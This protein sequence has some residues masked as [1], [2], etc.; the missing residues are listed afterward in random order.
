VSAPTSFATRILPRL[1]GLGVVGLLFAVVL[2]WVVADT[3]PK[4]GN[5]FAPGSL[6]DHWINGIAKFAL[7]AGL[8]TVAVGLAGVAFAPGRR[9]FCLFMTLVAAG[10]AFFC[11]LA[12]LGNAICQY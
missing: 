8:A 3:A 7:F 5:C 1:T 2:V 10:A 9:R 4:Q 6:G 12:G 11:L